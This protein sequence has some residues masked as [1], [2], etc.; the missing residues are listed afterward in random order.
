[1]R[2][3]TNMRIAVVTPYYKEPI[4][5]IRRCHESVLNQTHRDVMHIMVADGFPRQEI[6]SWE[7]CLHIPLPIGH[8]DS[9]D[10][11]R[12]V[13]CSSAASQQYGGIVLLDADNWFEP[14]HIEVLIN[15]HKQSQAPVVTCVRKLC[16]PDTGE[17]LATCWESDGVNFCD[18]NC[19]LITHTAFP[20][21]AAWGFRDNQTASRIING[22]DRLFW[23]A[24]VKSQV[25]RAHSKRPTVNYETV[26]ANH[27]EA[28]GLP[29]PKLAKVFVWLPEEQKFRVILY[30]EYRQRME[31]GV[32]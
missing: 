7:R 4:E 27:Y 32:L 17:L 16:R 6:N 28:L 19:Y 3:T 10:T 9:G 26:W 12:V 5:K 20:L 24:V 15:V 18:T 2:Y 29:I 21:L 14:E 25:G 22:G 8:N 31:R 30:D 13:G 11:P 1:M 23:N